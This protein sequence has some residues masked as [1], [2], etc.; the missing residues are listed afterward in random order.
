MGRLN[1]RNICGTGL[2]LA[3]C[4]MFST[5]AEGQTDLEST[6]TV[7]FKDA[8]KKP[9]KGRVASETFKEIVVVVEGGKIPVTAS[10]V[11]RIEYGTVP[12]YY[13]RAQEKSRR[14]DWKEAAEQF[15]KALSEARNSDKR[16][17][18][19]CLYYWALCLTRMG[20][21]ADAI[22]KWEE[23]L[24]QVPETRYFAEAYEELVRCELARGDAAAAKKRVEEGLAA[25]K[26]KG[27]ADS[28]RWRLDLM[29]CEILEAQKKFLPAKDEYLGLAR[30]ID[31]SDPVLAHLAKLRAARCLVELGQGPQAKQLCEEIL[32]A[33]LTDAVVMA[34]TWNT[35]GDLH[36]M[37]AETKK[38]PSLLREA[39]MAYLRGVVLYVPEEGQ[40]PAEHQKALFW[41]AYCHD[42]LKDTINDPKAR[43]VYRD[44]ARD[45]YGELIQAYEGSPLAEKASERRQRLAP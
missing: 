22:G 24:K 19:H 43:E 7:F 2:L 37:E 41:S 23:L 31:K 36:R 44:R 4:A 27:L 35:L 3:A 42:L 9:L 34:G 29:G 8:A 28:K 12:A 17:E 30:T 20:Q 32:R 33:K 11:D 5:G 15:R 14:G 45:L 13:D 21:W 6:D 16:F 39:L 10:N 18:Q 25:A 26:G 38:N 1:R 40:E